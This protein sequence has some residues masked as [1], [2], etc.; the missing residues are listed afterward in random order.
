MTLEEQLLAIGVIPPDVALKAHHPAFDE[1]EKVHDWR[2]H[3]SNEIKKLWY[4]F[5]FPQKCAIIMQAQAGAELEE[6]E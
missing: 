6:W 2:N 1:A 5:T 3:I 4:S